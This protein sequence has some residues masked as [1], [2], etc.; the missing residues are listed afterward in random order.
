MDP[1]DF[2][3]YRSLLKSNPSAFVEGVRGFCTFH[4]QAAVKQAGISETWDAVKPW[5]IAL[6]IGYGGMK[7]GS[8]WGRY[9]NKTDNPNGPVKGPLMKIVEGFLPKGKRIYWP[10]QDGY[11][12]VKSGKDKDYLAW[13]KDKFGDLPWDDPAAQARVETSAQG[14]RGF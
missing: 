7:L 5:L 13:R 11:E 14:L 10:G 3:R 2:R 8:G 12:A 6:A 9:A 1:Q 4:K